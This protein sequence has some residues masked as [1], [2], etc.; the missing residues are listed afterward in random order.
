MSSLIYSLSRDKVLAFR[1]DQGRETSQ[2]SESVLTERVTNP[3]VASSEH[4]TCYNSSCHQVENAAST[5]SSAIPSL[6]SRTLDCPTRKTNLGSHDRDRLALAKSN[7][8]LGQSAPRPSSSL[9][10]IGFISA[11]I[12]DPFQTYPSRFSA[13][14]V[15][16][17]IKYC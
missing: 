5:S 11:S 4:S 15:N 17:C 3:L 1:F 9:Y 10:P 6:R 16:W 2:P 7:N 14:V 12:L 13:C 8:T